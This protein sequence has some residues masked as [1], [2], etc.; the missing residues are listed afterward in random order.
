MAELL[1]LV[2]IRWIELLNKRMN[3]WRKYKN[4]D[5]DS[6]NSQ[7]KTFMRANQ[8]ISVKMFFFVFKHSQIKSLL[9][10][11]LHLFI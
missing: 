5:I 1:L 3:E 2:D 4:E 11:G 7:L 9:G 8:A 6:K 10:A